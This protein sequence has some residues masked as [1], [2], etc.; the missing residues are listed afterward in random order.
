MN[1]LIITTI[2]AMFGMIGC[3]SYDKVCNTSVLLI[4]KQIYIPIYKSPNGPKIDS[5]IN[6]TIN[7]NLALITIKQIK[8]NFAKVSF[9]GAINDTIQREGWIELKFLGINPAT[10]NYLLLYR[11]AN[12]KSF[13]CDTILNP[14]WGDLYPIFKCQGEWLYIRTQENNKWKE[15]W[16]APENQCSNPYTTCN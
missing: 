16:I 6:D 7:E 5:I 12:K 14:F 11:N 13:V 1:K 10:T 15:G 2:I 9:S 3:N 8:N 4:P